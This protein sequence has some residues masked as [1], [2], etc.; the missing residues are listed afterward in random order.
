MISVGGGGNVQWPR[1]HYLGPFLLMKL[2]CH[3]CTWKFVPFLHESTCRCTFCLH[4]TICRIFRHS[5]CVWSLMIESWFERAIFRK[6]T[7][8][9]NNFHQRMNVWCILLLSCLATITFVPSILEVLNW[10]CRE[11]HFSLVHCFP[12]WFV[13]SSTLQ[14]NL[15]V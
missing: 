6:I 15:C 1:W 13:A 7:L 11:H 4:A 12:D 8:F 3:H 10:T 2:L 14:T 9:K 5:L